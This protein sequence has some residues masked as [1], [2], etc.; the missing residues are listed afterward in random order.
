M[1][2]SEGW[3]GLPRHLSDPEHLPTRRP[4]HRLGCPTARL[5]F[6]L[7]SCRCPRSSPSRRQASRL[8]PRP[9]WAETVP[10]PLG[11]RAGWPYRRRICGPPSTAGA[12]RSPLRHGVGTG[13]ASGP[14]TTHR[15]SL[16]RCRQGFASPQG[17]CPHGSSSEHPPPP[18]TLLR[19]VLSAWAGRGVPCP[20]SRLRRLLSGLLAALSS[21]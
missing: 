14:P 15:G 6:C 5:S 1:R 11:I 17:V 4:A 20:C 7:A 18:R 12:T 16:L 21:L 9:P 8:P 10:R 19:G 3:T 13:F 2:P